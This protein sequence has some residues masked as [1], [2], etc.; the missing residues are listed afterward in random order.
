MAAYAAPTRAN[1][2]G[3]SAWSKP[4]IWKASPIPRPTPEKERRGGWWWVYGVWEVDV[5]E[6]ELLLLVVVGAGGG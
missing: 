5:G 1:T 4:F 3:S 2:P 6:E